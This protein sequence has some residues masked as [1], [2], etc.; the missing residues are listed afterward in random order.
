MIDS[1][2][3]IDEGIDP[4]VITN[5][6]E[7]KLL[8]YLGVKLNLIS[9]ISCGSK[10][11]IITL[12]LEKGGLLCKN[13]YKDELLFPINIIKV[14]NMYYL[15]DIKSISKLSLDK[16]IINNINKYLTEYYEDYTGLYIKSKDFLKT[17]E[18]I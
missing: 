12:S 16:D 8:D 18:S 9:C 10:K 6:V 13:C 15:V 5:I 1:L 3:K 2:I 7:V 17:I 11:D 4:V 14:L